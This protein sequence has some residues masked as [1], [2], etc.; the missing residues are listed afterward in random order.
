MP[1]KKNSKCNNN[2]VEPNL[3]YLPEPC[4]GCE[5]VIDAHCVQYNGPD[6]ECIHIPSGSRLDTV[7]EGLDS[8][9]CLLAEGG[10]YSDYDFACLDEIQSEQQFV[11][12]ISSIICEILGT[13]TP[14]NITSLSYIIDLINNLAT[15]HFTFTDCAEPL[16]NLPPDSLL[17]DVLIALRAAICAHKER[18][19]NIDTEIS[20]ITTHLTIIDTEITDI[21]T[22]LNDH[23]ERIEILEGRPIPNNT[24]EHVKVSPTDTTAG[25]LLSK[26]D[27]AGSNV[28]I[29][30]QNAGSNEKL[31]LTVTIPTVTDH[32]VGTWSGDVPGFLEGKIDS[33]NATGISLLTH[34]SGNIIRITPTL[35]FDQITT[36]VLNQITTNTTAHE[37]FC[38]IVAECIGVLIPCAPPAEL[39]VTEAGVD[40][41]TVQWPA[42][43]QS[44]TTGYFLEYKKA[45]DTNYIVINIDPTQG[46]YKIIGLTPGTDYNIRIKTKCGISNSNYTI[47]NPSPATTSCPIPTNLNVSFS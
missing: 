33:D 11:E 9:I 34:R 27:T 4:E 31:R 44:S 13:Q 41:I 24:D 8:V 21:Q 40:Y 36:G 45:T 16:V 29:T 30:Q 47:S 19:D 5:E 46:T 3:N 28:A 12:L 10:D 22:E 42:A 17:L 7:I 38:N 25:Y 18:L 26:F 43:P 15:P 35:L 39:N 1:N 37:Q 14:G 2:S 6:T 32:F 20:D 23:E